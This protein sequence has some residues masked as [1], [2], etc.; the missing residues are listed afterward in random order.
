MKKPSPTTEFVMSNGL[1]SFKK[2]RAEK[3]PHKNQ[4]PIPKTAVF[5]RIFDT[6]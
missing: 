1:I 2:K 4:K 6:D 5:L 3:Q